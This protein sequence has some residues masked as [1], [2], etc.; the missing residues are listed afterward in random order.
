M[1]TL[2]S[3]KDPKTSVTN[4]A[5]KFHAVENLYASD[6]SLFPTSSGYN[7]THTIVSLATRVAGEM[8]FPGSPERVLT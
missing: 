7:P 5:G 3:G 6:G 2:R 8:V 4:A 1:G